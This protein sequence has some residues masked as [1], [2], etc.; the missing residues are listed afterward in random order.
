LTDTANLTFA[1][2]DDEIISNQSAGGFSILQLD[3]PGFAGH[4][5]RWTGDRG[6]TLLQSIGFD[7]FGELRTNYAQELLQHWFMARN[8]EE[9]RG[10]SALA[11]AEGISLAPVEIID[12]SPGRMELLRGGALRPDS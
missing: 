3:M 2:S 11:E 1:L 6:S 8:F 5:A 7:G 12:R 9:T 4:T 10:E